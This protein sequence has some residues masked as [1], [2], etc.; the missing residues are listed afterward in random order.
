MGAKPAARQLDK[1]AGPLIVEG[2]ATVMI[3]DAPA[4][5][6][7]PS[8]KPTITLPDEFKLE[9]AA[10]V[11][12]AA[13]KYAPLDEPLTIAQT[14]SNY[15]D[16]PQSEG[17]KESAEVNPHN[18]PDDIE[19][20]CPTMKVVDYSYRLSPSFTLGDF[21]QGAIFSHPI[22]AQQGLSVSEIVCNLKHL[23]INICEPIVSQ[24]GK[25]QLNS[26]FRV[27]SG[28]S[29]HCK[30]MAVDIQWSG[31]SNQEYLSRAKW[32]AENL[33][34]DQIILEKGRS[35]WIHVS[36]NRSGSRR[37]ALSMLGDGK[38]VSGLHIG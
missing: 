8:V 31:I 29:Q 32:I 30:G 34:C 37:Q 17:T 15:P 36:F 13:G 38:F 9:N 21:S 4:Y 22:T 2:S 28:K 11:I 35:Y 25:F 7:V 33:N 26:G 23:A 1:V 12:K 3:G 6:V 14:P 20:G 5:V 16:D 19:V 18:A 27:G 24:F 10:P